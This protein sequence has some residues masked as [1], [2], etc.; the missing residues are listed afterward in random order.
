MISRPELSRPAELRNKVTSNHAGRRPISPLGPEGDSGLFD[1]Q[2]G[3]RSPKDLSRGP[4]EK[5]REEDYPHRILYP[6]EIHPY[7]RV[8]ALHKGPLLLEGLL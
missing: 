5:G 6:L 4:Q 3:D 2:T 7:I 8:D 1:Q